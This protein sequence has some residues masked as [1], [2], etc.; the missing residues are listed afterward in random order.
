MGITITQVDAFTSKPFSGN[1]AAVC[2][3]ETTVD[4]AW[5]Q[6]VAAEMNLSETAF[7][8]P[9]GNGFRL[10]WFTP[11]VEVDLCGHAT[12]A[13]AHTL[14]E[15]GYVSP[16]QSIEFYTRS[17]L[18]SAALEEDWI[19]LDFPAKPPQPTPPPEA[20]IRAL[21]IA[22]KYA[23][24]DGSDY[25]LEV[26]SEAELRQLKP[27]F[28]V[29]ETVPTRGIIVTSVSETEEYDFVSRFFAPAAGVNEDPVTGSAHCCL[30]PFWQ[31]KLGKAEFVAYQASKRGGVLRVKLNGDRVLLSGQATTVFRGELSSHCG[32]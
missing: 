5:M 32:F 22:P 1:P 26:D 23:G 30:A 27:D 15:L 11:A 2:I 9:E 21:G 17:G 6:N 12:L 3:L 14:W 10:R 19:A 29:L 24:F 7:V 25:L 16:T 28:A 13:T 20:L 31:Q 4:A 18:L 8:H